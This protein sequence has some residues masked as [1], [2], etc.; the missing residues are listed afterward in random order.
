M[1]ALRQV[2]RKSWAAPL[3]RGWLALRYR[4]L[5]RRYG[6][7]VLERIDG[8][9]FIVLPEVFN[10]VLLRSGEVLARAV[11]RIPLNSPPGA[12]LPSVLDLGTGSGVG[13]VFAARR[14]ARV[15]AVDINPEAVRCA[16]MNALLNRVED[17]MQVLLGDLFEPVAGQRFNWVLFNPPYFRGRPRTQLDYAWRGEGVLERFGSG[18]REIL[19]PTPAGSNGPGG[20]ALVVLSTDG[21]S[22]TALRSLKENGFALRPLFQRDFV[23]E[24]ITAY[25]V[26]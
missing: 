8:V 1:Y 13:G 12:G 20:R 19:R 2:G 21:D 24:V 9:P 22:P 11:M 3:A 5:E 16:R 23:N 18:L 6:R 4:V 15:T 25:Q 7:L 14:G 17:R 26:E 10:P